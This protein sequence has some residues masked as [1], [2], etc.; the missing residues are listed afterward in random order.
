M[1]I[2]AKHYYEKNLQRASGADMQ[3]NLSQ[4]IK[5]VPDAEIRKGRRRG[6]ARGGEEADPD[7]TPPFIVFYVDM[8]A[9]SQAGRLGSTIRY[10]RVQFVMQEF[11]IQVESSILNDNLKFVMETL[12][13]FSYEAEEDE[14]STEAAFLKARAQRRRE[15]CPGVDASRGVVF[16]ESQAQVD[17]VSFGVIQLGAIQ[18]SLTFKLEKRSLKF[19]F[20]NPRAFFGI[21]AVLYPLLQNFAQISDARIKLKELILLEGYYS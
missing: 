1:V 16:D 15:L 17:K 3:A 18:V 10:E 2:G 14:I 19:D 12:S 11:F 20:T 21:G 13:T 9:K 7:E 5:I 6:R 4:F 8:S